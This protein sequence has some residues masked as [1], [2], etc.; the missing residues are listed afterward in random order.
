MHLSALTH[1]FNEGREDRKNWIR[2][3]TL[4]PPHMRS[5]PKWGKN[6]NILTK[7]TPIQFT[8]DLNDVTKVSGKLINEITAENLAPDF[9]P[10]SAMFYYIRVQRGVLQ[11]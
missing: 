5:G 9:Q 3:I 4:T 2:E 1:H 7:N 8:I 6:G 10:H 11:K